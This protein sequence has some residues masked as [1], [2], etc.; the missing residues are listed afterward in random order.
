MKFTTA[1]LA[2]TTMIAAAA[3]APAAH[4]LVLAT[5]TDSYSV[6]PTDQGYVTFTNNTGV[7]E[8]NVTVSGTTFNQVVALVAA[9]HSATVSVGDLDDVCNGCSINVSFMIGNTSYAKT[10]AYDGSV[11]ND[12]YGA[13]GSLGTITGSIPEPATMAVL[14]TG[15]IG[16]AA[17]R[18]RKV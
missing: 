16:L 13:S 12:N 8:T 4:A 7:A 2:T 6:K 3:V 11:F 14:G 17:M 18:R 10:F 1:L 5:V 15:L 9:G